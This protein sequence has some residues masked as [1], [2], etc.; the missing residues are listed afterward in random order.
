MCS[1]PAMNL[2]RVGYWG[3]WPQVWSQCLWPNSFCLVTQ[4]AGPLVSV[5]LLTPTESF[6]LTKEAFGGV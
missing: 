5:L 4:T 6:Q 1:N 2:W 3:T